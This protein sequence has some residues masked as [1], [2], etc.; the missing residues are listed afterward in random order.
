MK[1]LDEKK[2]SEN[3]DREIER[4]LKE[5]R[6]NERNI[7]QENLR[8]IPETQADDGET[9][10]EYRNS[11]SEKDGLDFNQEDTKKEEEEDEERQRRRKL[12]RVRKIAKEEVK[13]KVKKVVKKAAK[14]FLKILIQRIIIPILGAIV[15]FFLATWYIWLGLA[16]IIFLIILG[17]YIYENPSEIT[18]FLDKETFEA[19]K[20]IFKSYF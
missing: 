3:K 16:V 18:N 4:E 10:E 12:E 9:P 15:S 11:S 17:H 19:L 14:K 20:A 1:E 13:K 2:K 5:K 8:E 6:F 7:N